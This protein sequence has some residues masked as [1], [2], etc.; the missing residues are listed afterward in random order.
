M[1]SESIT[2]PLVNRKSKNFI[3]LERNKELPESLETI[4]LALW[5]DASNMDGKQN[6]TLM[7]SSVNGKI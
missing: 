5:L 6:T 1:T 2:E 3:I 7:N 4:G